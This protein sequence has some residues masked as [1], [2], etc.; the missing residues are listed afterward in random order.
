MEFCSI[1][2]E[3]LFVEE[4]NRFKALSPRVYEDLKASIEKSGIM[5]PLI[6]TP[7]DDGKGYDVQSG[8]YRRKA[9]YELKH[10]TAPCCIVGIGDLEGAVDSEK[11]RKSLRR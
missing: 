10:P 6:V 11:L 8:R 7:R 2:V 1:P 5:Q 4:K 3:Q 9:A